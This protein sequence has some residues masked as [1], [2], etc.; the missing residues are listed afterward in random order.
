MKKWDLESGQVCLCTP[1]SPDLGFQVG[2]AMGRN[3]LIY[4][5][6]LATVIVA[7]ELESGG[8]WSGA[9]EALK[10]NLCPVLVRPE[11]GRGAAALIKQGGVAIPR[12][13]DLGDLLKSA[14]RVQES[15]L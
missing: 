12:A 6:S 14:T 1:F 11:G 10:G 9:T 15:L 3:K 13:S 8:T 2:N 7:S 5:G 4:A